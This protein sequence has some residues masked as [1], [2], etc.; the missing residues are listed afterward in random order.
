M[1]RSE[2]YVSGVV[3]YKARTDKAVLVAVDSEEHW[4]PRTLL[5]YSCDKIIDDLT[6][7]EEFTLSILEWKAQQIGLE[8]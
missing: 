6:R 7:G 4:I 2:T 5:S 1:S 8:Y 3:F